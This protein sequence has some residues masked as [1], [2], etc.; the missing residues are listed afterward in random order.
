VRPRAPSSRGK[1]QIADAIIA[2]TSPFAI[3]AISPR[4]DY[5]GYFLPV[6]CMCGICIL[7]ATSGIITL[8]T[9]RCNA[10][11]GCTREYAYGLLRT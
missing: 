11:I 4:G 3:T 1:L 5:R 2:S 10:W 9:P 6:I 7:L 8:H